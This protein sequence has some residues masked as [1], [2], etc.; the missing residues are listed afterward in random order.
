LRLAEYPAKSV[1]DVAMTQSV[2]V[3]IFL[4]LG[5]T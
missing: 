4:Y 2:P 3:C 5:I 1:S